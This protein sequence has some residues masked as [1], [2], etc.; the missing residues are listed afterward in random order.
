MAMR[1]LAVDTALGACSVAVSSGGRI[2]AH[3]WVAMQRGHAEALGPM[4][5]GTMREAGLGFGELDRLAVTTGPGTFT[6]QRV[7]LAFMRALRLALSRPL[8]GLTTLEVMAAAAR[9][10]TGLPLVAVLHEA[11]RGEVYA[12]MF[13][14]EVP[15][16]PVQISEYAAMMQ[17]LAQAASGRALAF[18]GTAAESAAGW[19][20]EQKGEAVL[21]MVRQPDARFAATLCETR[22]MPQHAPSP[23]YLRP[24]DAKPPAAR[25]VIRRAGPD[26]AALLATLYSASLTDAWDTGFFADLLM[27]EGTIALIAERF[28]E[29]EGFAAARVAADEAEILAI[30]VRTADRRQGIGRRLVVEI[31]RLAAD[32]GALAL[33]LEVAAA[34]LP[35]RGL[36]GKLGFE[37]VGTRKR[38]Y[39]KEDGDA[40]ILRARLHR[41]AGLGKPP[42]VA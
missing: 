41:G 26:D 19:Y 7:G 24:P 39:G 33:F 32:R 8:L 25:H 21:S 1:I 17:A 40:L 38:Y 13:D 3:R 11:K 5:E 6:G 16:L 15:V 12:A 23:L 30:G 29:P 35:A 20:R 27:A 31:A 34:N 37:A 36:Y 28:G 9:E 18:A 14:G 10:E 2:V 4:V 42:E 22:A